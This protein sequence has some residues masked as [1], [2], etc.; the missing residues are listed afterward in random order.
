MAVDGRSLVPSIAPLVES[1]ERF[2][3]QA[4][5]DRAFKLSGLQ[6]Q[7][8]IRDVQ[9]QSGQLQLQ[10]AKA[11]QRRQQIIDVAN[12][13]RVEFIK[14]RA[15]LDFVLEG[16]PEGLRNSIARLMG[17]K[18]DGDPDIPEFTDFAKRA[19]VD[20][21]AIFEELTS[22][23]ANIVQGISTIDEILGRSK[24]GGF[25]LS[26]GQ[27]RFDASGK[28]IAAGKDKAQSGRDLLT[29]VQSSQILPNGSTV[30]V[31]K[32][33]STRVTGP[34]GRPLTG[35]EREQAVVAANEFGIDIQ[36]R[37][38]GGRSDAT[39]EAS[40]ASNLI[41]RGVS[42][43]ESTATIRRALTLLDQVKTGGLASVSLATKQRLGI[44]G[45]DEGELSNSLGKSV[46]SQ[47]RETFGAA[48]TENEGKR[49]ERI[50]AGFGKSA[51]TNRRLL[52]QA[53][54]IAES[55][56]GRARKA[57]I[58]RG[59]TAE[60]ADIDDLLTFSLELNDSAQ[61]ADLVDNGDGT[62]TLPDGQIVRRKGG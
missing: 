5:E 20:A 25:T 46:L 37:R 36:S 33:G 49:L 14:D 59:F 13:N 2:T 32:D 60:A 56:A 58:K 22:N 10:N 26:E 34:Q 12:E 40:R 44:E 15:D 31:F 47:L 28:P 27:T 35:P 8:D 23:R 45:A 38:A 3:P 16:G 39:G 18:E 29:Q 55:T 50:E 57:A 48:F 61:P 11:A 51:A 52:G 7:S 53:L 4:R 24:P 30:Q 1:L 62:F 43:A 19:M 6:Q 41:A 21:E 42:A 9:L 54:K 17:T